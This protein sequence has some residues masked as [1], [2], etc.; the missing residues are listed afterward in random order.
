MQM[1]MMEALKWPYKKENWV[2][3]I[4][5]PG[6]VCTGLIVAFVVV[7]FVFVAGMVGAAAIGA[8]SEEMG[9]MAMVLLFLSYLGVVILLTALCAPIYGYF[10]EM[11]YVLR[12]EGY[13]ADSPLWS[14]RFKEYSINGLKIVCFS[15]V[16]NIIHVFISLVIPLLSMPFGE[17]G[18]IISGLLSFIYSLCTL[19]VMPFIYSAFIH[20]AESK[21]LKDMFNVS[22]AVEVGLQCYWGV[23][24]AF[25]ACILISLGYMILYV[26]SVC[27]VVGIPF[28]AAAHWTTSVHLL[29]QGFDN[30]KADALPA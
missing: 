6:A 4:I 29:V 10:W 19:A 30:Y 23:V 16:L 18:E 22:R 24:V 17:V 9:I 27:T 13:E 26:V 3:A 14:G 5:M 7:Y 15:V 1:D 8:A 20:T 25:L 11:A 21:S 28:V 2:S 12:S